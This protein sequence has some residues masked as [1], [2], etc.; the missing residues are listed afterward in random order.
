MTMMILIDRRAILLETNVY[1]MMRDGV[2]HQELSRSASMKIPFAPAIL[3]CLLFST[4]SC[5]KCKEAKCSECETFMALSSWFEHGVEEV[6]AHCDKEKDPCAKQI[7]DKI[8]P[9]VDKL[10]KKVSPKEVCKASGFC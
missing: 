5:K 7:C 4:G 10:K 6:K 8:T 9:H 2:R 3:L 1:L